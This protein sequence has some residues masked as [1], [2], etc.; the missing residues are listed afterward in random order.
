MAA[1][2]ESRRGI[3]TGADGGAAERQ[4]VSLQSAAR[5][6]SRDRFHL[7]GVSAELL[8]ETHG[9]GVLKMRAADLEHVPELAAALASSARRS[10]SIAGSRFAARSR[11]AAM[12]IAV[13]NTSLLDWPRFT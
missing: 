4:F 12:W 3:Q 5:F 8:A 9:H 2:R 13:G 6:A 1:A 10:A 11:A 7:A